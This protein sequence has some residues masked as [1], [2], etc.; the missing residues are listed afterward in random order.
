MI[1]NVRYHPTA[2]TIVDHDFDLS[3][4]FDTNF[5]RHSFPVINSTCQAF[6][7][8][9]TPPPLCLNI[10]HLSVSTS[11]TH[12]SNALHSFNGS[13]SAHLVIRF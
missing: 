11:Q 5:L 8:T 13:K 10:L 2:D 4:G 1:T 3:I 6:L 9:L 7:S 12:T